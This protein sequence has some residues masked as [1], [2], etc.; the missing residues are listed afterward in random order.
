MHMGGIPQRSA[1]GLRPSVQTL[2]SADCSAVTAKRLRARG[3]RKHRGH[4]SC[5]HACGN[6]NGNVFRRR[7]QATVSGDGF[8][9]RFQAT[10]SS[11]GS[12][13]RSGIPSVSRPTR[14]RP[15]T[16][17]NGLQSAAG[18]VSSF[19]TRRVSASTSVNASRVS[20]AGPAT[21][22][23]QRSMIRG[24]DIKSMFSS[25]KS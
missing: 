22:S 4:A 3:R 11:T 18:C 17:R 21:C 5:R 24:I 12:T 6:R 20:T 8:R 7:F 23:I 15:P 19:A 13:I 16:L 9:R 10:V 25:K 14:N 2:Q 1:T